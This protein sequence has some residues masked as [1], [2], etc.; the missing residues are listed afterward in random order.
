MKIKYYKLSFL[1]FFLLVAENM[2]FANLQESSKKIHKDIVVNPDALVEIDNAFGDLNISSW[3]ENK[4]IIDVLI[5]VEGRNSKSV[6]EK[7]DA[8]DVLF[9]LSPE[10][11]IAKTK[12]EDHWSFKWFSSNAIN[13]RINYTVKLPKSNSVNLTNDYGTIRLNRLEGQAT[14]SCDYG[15]MILGDLNATNNLLNFDYTSNSTID[16]IKGGIINADYSGFEIEQAGEI[17]LNADYT[18]ASFDLVNFLSFKNDYGKLITENIGTLRGKGDYLTLKCGTVTEQLSLDNE[19][20]LIQVKQIKP[21]VKS[22]EID[23]EY[24]GVQLGIDEDWSF[25]YEINLDYAGFRSTLPLDHSIEN[26]RITEKYYKG[27]YNQSNSLSTLKITSEY[28]G[29]KL[30]PSN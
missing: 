20:G 7:L 5:T 23:A 25:S 16:F 17:E 14:I 22:V 8:I 3:D 9:S 13:Y 30:N 29:V 26:S 28:G 19:F 15:K 27:I 18:N 24:T 1:L 6:Q 11:V 12:I 2:L 4:V 21:S 10:K